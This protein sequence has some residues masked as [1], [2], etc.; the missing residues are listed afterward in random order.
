MEI[1]VIGA[2]FHFEVSGTG[3]Y[4]NAQNSGKGC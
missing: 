4:C 1:S 3:V 2:Y